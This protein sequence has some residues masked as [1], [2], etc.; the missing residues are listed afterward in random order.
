ML[1]VAS[2]DLKSNSDESAPT[3]RLTYQWLVM[4]NRAAFPLTP[5]H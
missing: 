5:I 4:F 3:L 2:V 1:C